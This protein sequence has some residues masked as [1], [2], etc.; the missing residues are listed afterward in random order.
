[1]RIAKWSPVD[2]EE[3]RRQRENWARLRREE[4]V[5]RLRF[6]PRPERPRDTRR[7]LEPFVFGSV[8]MTPPEQ[9]A[10]YLETFRPV[11]GR[12]D[13][14]RQAQRYLT[15][16]LSN[17]KRKNGETIEAAVPGARQQGVW[18]FLVRSPWSAEALD[19][20]RVCDALD[21][22]GQGGATLDIIIDEVG[23]AKKGKL[24][25]GVARQYVGALGKV[26]NAQVVVTLHGVTDD[27]GLPL[28]GQMYLPQVWLDDSA[29]R[30]RS[31]IAA[32]HTFATKPQIAL[33]LLDR[34]RQ[35]GLRCGTIFADAGYS[36]RHFI[37]ELRARQLPFCLGV[38][39]TTAFWLPGQ[40]WLPAV[41]PPPYSGRG[42]PPVGQP[43]KPHLHTADQIRAAVPDAEWHPIAYRDGTDGKPLIREFSALR[44]VLGTDGPDEAPE[45]VWLLLER[46]SGPTGRDDVKQYVLGAPEN[47]T[48]DELAQIAHRRPLIERNSYENAKQEVGL[49]Q[50]QGRSWVGFHHHLSMVW[51]GLTFLILHRRPLPPPS[52]D[53]PGPPSDR[54][55]LDAQASG[56]PGPPSPP[57]SASTL[58][59]G[60]V[61]VPAT[62]A[63]VAP[64]P[65][66]RPRQRWESV[67]EVHRRLIEWWHGMRFRELLFAGIPLPLPAIGVLLP[68]LAPGHAT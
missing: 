17:L 20:A 32:D 21:Q 23:W 57:P 40:P 3:E 27:F 59:L 12:V 67:Q 10:A 41:P 50:Y 24:S 65:P 38:K 9:L 48:L 54:P 64:T 60:A 61:A 5:R 44:A 31:R 28:L 66:P 25:V 62:L 11:F 16:L 51:L 47:A 2:E 7:K 45:P 52:A 33:T 37:R 68:R 19:R 26:D 18:D 1:M 58:F 46:P 34:V 4:E 8:A 29:R 15:G 14:L 42:R 36:D 6:G 13:T 55:P 39:S 53:Q 63:P 35:W 49:S 43:A 22:A 56:E 30:E